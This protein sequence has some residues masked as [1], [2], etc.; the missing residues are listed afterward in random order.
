MYLV[1]YFILYLLL[2]FV[3]KTR[4]R[5]NNVWVLLEWICMLPSCH[6]IVLEKG[7]KL[8]WLSSFH[9]SQSELELMNIHDYCRV[10]YHVTDC[11]LKRK[12]RRWGDLCPGWKGFFVAN[13]CVIQ[14]PHR[15]SVLNECSL[16]PQ[17][18]DDIT[19]TSSGSCF[20]RL[21]K[22]LPEPQ[23]SFHCPFPGSCC[24]LRWGGSLL[25]TP[26]H[27][28]AGARPRSPTFLLLSHLSHAA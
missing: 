14:T 21:L 11:W 27:S 23:E 2:H 26:K 9:H 5:L 18:H 19:T 8:A 17:Y 13:V 12:A 22:S 10:A 24:W 28:A 3:C 1:V 4:C 7:R 6:G 15:P 25:L 20:P 16:R